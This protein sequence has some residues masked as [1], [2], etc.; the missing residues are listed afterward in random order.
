MAVALVTEHTRWVVA[1]VAGCDERRVGMCA[2]IAA[3]VSV[4]GA[5]VRSGGQRAGGIGCAGGQ[6]VDS[7]YGLV[8]EAQIV[9]KLCRG[10]AR[11][12]EVPCFVEDR[13][14]ACLRKS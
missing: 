9:E 4:E 3:L 2:I 14:V 12:L 10:W 6:V 7:R 11:V 8:F 13:V 1:I 5:G